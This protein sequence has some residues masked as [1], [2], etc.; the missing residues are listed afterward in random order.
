MKLSMPLTGFRAIR[1]VALWL[2][3][4]ALMVQGLAPLCAGGIGGGT[5]SNVASVVICTAHGFQTVSV[6]A[7]GKPLP[8][9]P[10]KSM[11][12]CCSAC[13]A[14]GFIVLSPIP[15]S[16][17]SNIAYDGASIAPAPVLPPRFYSSYVTRGPPASV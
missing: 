4:A 12:D 11:S 8:Q 6:D 9:A 15:V 10:G 14:G 5:G 1:L 3:L 2:G 17:P 16:L 13:H 7:D